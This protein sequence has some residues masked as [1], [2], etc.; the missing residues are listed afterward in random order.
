MK[1][2]FSLT[3]LKT[4]GKLFATET[5]KWEYILQLNNFFH[6]EKM[7]YLKTLCAFVVMDRSFML[8]LFLWD[9]PAEERNPFPNWM[10]G[11]QPWSEIW[12]WKFWPAVKTVYVTYPFVLLPAYLWGLKWFFPDVPLLRLHGFSIIFSYMEITLE[13]LLSHEENG[14]VVQVHLAF[15]SC[16]WRWFQWWWYSAL[17]P[18]VLHSFNISVMTIS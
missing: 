13:R 10:F 1:G 3:Q 15:T 17:N 18:I 9:F 6:E 7:G 8:L 11:E 5:K 14:S 12:K 16:P 2:K 4:R